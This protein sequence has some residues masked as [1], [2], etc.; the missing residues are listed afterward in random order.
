MA[1]SVFTSCTP[2]RLT[3][4]LD[5]SIEKLVQLGGHG[6][7]SNCMATQGYVYDVPEWPDTPDADDLAPET[8]TTWPRR[9]FYSAVGQDHV[10]RF[11]LGIENSALRQSLAGSDP[12]ALFQESLNAAN[13]EQR[14]E[15]GN[16]YIDASVEC[17][18]TAFV[19]F[20]DFFPDDAE[21][22]T[23]IWSERVFAIL[24]ES[25]G[26]FEY[27]DCMSRAGFDGLEHPFDSKRFL[28]DKFGGDL[29]PDAQEPSRSIEAGPK[30]K[31]ASDA[32]LEIALA[33]ASCRRP[34]LEEVD[35]ELLEAS[36]TFRTEFELQLLSVSTAWDEVVLEA[37]SLSS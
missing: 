28:V 1:I 5:R 22:L 19:E 32:E 8:F 23:Q 30:W 34:G 15:F 36:E 14:E 9:E 27:E 4:E 18:E 37:S 35:S 6:A 2:T 3:F 24:E 33:D 21:E 12:I 11:R 29:F 7:I 20:E 17:S 31:S 10:A 26:L 13:S 16:G 25:D